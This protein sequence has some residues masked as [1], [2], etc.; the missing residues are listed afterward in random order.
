MPVTE[1]RT[2]PVTRLVAVVAAA[3]LIAGCGGGAAPAGST[4]GASSPSV[5]SRP[6]GSAAEGSSPAP[7]T[8][9]TVTSSAFPDGGRIPARF[10]CDGP[11]TAPPLAWSG[12]PASARSLAVVVQDPDAPGGTYTHWVVAGLPPSA[13]SLDGSDLPSGA[14]QAITSAGRPGYAPPCPPSGTHRYR[15]TVLA[16]TVA[17]PFADG[18]ATPDALTAIGKADIASGTLVGRYSRG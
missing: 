7:V 6:V 14:V 13:T 15:F 4:P 12:A 17:E 18:A 16:L 10:T 9:I 8:A 5:P 2:T 3:V 11:G 1:R